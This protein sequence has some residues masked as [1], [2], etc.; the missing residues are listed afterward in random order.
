[1]KEKNEKVY[2]AQNLY[3]M[4]ILLLILLFCFLGPYLRHIKV[5]RLRAELELQPLAY[6]R[7]TAM[8]DPSCVYDLHHSSRQH[9]ILGEARDQTHILMDPIRV[10]YCW[11]TMRTLFWWNN[12][13]HKL[14]S[15]YWKPELLIQNNFEREEWGSVLALVHIKIDDKDT[16][17]KTL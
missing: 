15:Q 2:F 6:T 16:A 4:G 10:H 1:M 7:T 13:W 9:Q 5:P 11:V 3:L 17:I 14:F 12:Y 8:P